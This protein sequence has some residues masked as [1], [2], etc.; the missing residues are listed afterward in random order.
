MWTLAIVLLLVF[1]VIG[2]FSAGIRASFLFLGALVGGMVASP[3]G[4]ALQP[5]MGKIGI[6]NPVYQAI[7]PAPIVFLLVLL[8]VFGI[9]FAVQWKVAQKFK[10]TRDDVDR[11][12][13][14][15]MNRAFGIGLGFLTGIVFFFLIGGAIY[16]GGYL[17]A[18]LSNEESDPAFIKFMNK[19][20]EDMHTIGLDKAMAGL[21]PAG[22]RFYEVSDVLGL[23]YK[24]PLLQAR[25]AHYPD[26]FALG[27]RSEIQ[28][29]GNDK[30][31]TEML[32]GKASVAQI[33]KHD[34]TQSIL[35]NSDLMSQFLATD[36][37]DLQAYLRTGKSPKYADQ[38]LI[39]TWTLDKD[40]VL[41][42]LRKTKPDI[43]GNELMQVRSALDK[44]GN[45]TIQIAPDNKVFAKQ[46]AAPAAA[47]PNPAAPAPAP[48]FNPYA[49]RYPGGGRRGGAPVAQAPAPPPGPTIP[50]LNGEFSWKD[51]NGSYVITVP[52]P[53]G[54]SLDLPATVSDEEL[55]L[56]APV[57]GFN[58]VFS[59]QEV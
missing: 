15:R 23:L 8:A 52:G 36:L 55:I 2:F 48:A 3:G 42:N 59:R 26:F 17:T 30:E 34:R 35:A 20:R 4:R 6:K 28:D 14:E 51:N 24:N 37:K 49:G 47:A 57:V 5:L 32:F 7:F 27:Q 19:A 33:I 16:S 50:T 46:D 25:L 12:R 53:G 18:Q 10:F 40:A 41:T 54:K 11:I 9:G 45:V 31:Y 13:W 56:A 44:S 21:A 58:L 22:A 43:K 29:I 39:G 38:K 1:G